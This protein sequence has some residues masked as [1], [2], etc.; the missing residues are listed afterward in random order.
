MQIL[1]SN[2]NGIAAV[3][4]LKFPKSK[5]VFRLALIAVEILAL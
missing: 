3:G 2:R 5:M 1:F 4:N